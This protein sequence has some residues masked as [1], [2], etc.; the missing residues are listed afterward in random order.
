MLTLYRSIGGTVYLLGKP[1][2]TN[3]ETHESGYVVSVARMREA[4][5]SGSPL[6]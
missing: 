4:P 5:K 3:T 2:V 1:K 6:P